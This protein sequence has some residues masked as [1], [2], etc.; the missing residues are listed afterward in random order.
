M[1]HGIYDPTKE[2]NWLH[3][4]RQIGLALSPALKKILIKE[5]LGKHLDIPEITLAGTYVKLNKQKHRFQSNSDAQ[6]IQVLDTFFRSPD[7]IHMFV[8]SHFCYPPGTKI[9]TFSIN[10]P[11]IIMY[12]EIKPLRLILAAPKLSP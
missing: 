7:D 10:K 6:E 4:D 1:A 12:K 2:I 11:L 9:V 5:L 8:T 3:G